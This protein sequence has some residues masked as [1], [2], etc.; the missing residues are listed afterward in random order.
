MPVKEENHLVTMLATDLV[1]ATVFILFPSHSRQ[2]LILG[3]V[4][5][6]RTGFKI[7]FPDPGVFGKQMK[8]SFARYVFWLRIGHL[9]FCDLLESINGMGRCTSVLEAW[10][11]PSPSTD[12]NPKITFR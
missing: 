1:V 3:P 5:S 7:Q 2:F 10:T 4:H 8:K 6:I 11:A 12:K 9:F